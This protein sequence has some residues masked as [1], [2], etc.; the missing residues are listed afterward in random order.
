MKIVRIQRKSQCRSN[1]GSFSENTGFG[2]RLLIVHLS[3]NSPTLPW[4]L[5]DLEQIS[6]LFLYQEQPSKLVPLTSQTGSKP[7]SINASGRNRPI[8]LSV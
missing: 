4:A 2:A 8:Y 7:P 1:W 6:D 5:I 3:I